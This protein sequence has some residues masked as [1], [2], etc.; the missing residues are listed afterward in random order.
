LEKIILKCTECGNTFQKDGSVIDKQVLSCPVCDANYKAVVKEG[1][2][3]LED[4]LF[5]ETDLGEL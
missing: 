4:F 2:V 5:E 3:H 1:K